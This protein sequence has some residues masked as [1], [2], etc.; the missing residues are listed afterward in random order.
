MDNQLI[1]IGT[2]KEVNLSQCGLSSIPFSKQRH[3][4]QAT[5]IDLSH[6]QLR[7]IQPLSHGCTQLTTLLLDH[8]VLSS[9]SEIYRLNGHPKLRSLSLSQNPLCTYDGYRSIV[10][11]LLPHLDVLDGKTI[12]QVSRRLP[13]KKGSRP[14]HSAEGTLRRCPRSS[15]T[16]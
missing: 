16:W 6:N 7:S 10:I 12:L 3:P 1:N 13:R 2:S 8:N 4:V 5:L 9:F 11:C 14:R 15:T